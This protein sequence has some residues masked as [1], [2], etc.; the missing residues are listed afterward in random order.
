MLEFGQ[1]YT[2]P[3]EMKT[4]PFLSNEKSNIVSDWMTHK[5]H[6]LIYDMHEGSRFTRTNTL[7]Q[8]WKNYN[9]WALFVNNPPFEVAP[10]SSFTIL[11][12]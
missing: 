12:L 8:T 4:W 2:F 10:I 5:G 3:P 7:N 1:N 11:Q 6:T 9:I